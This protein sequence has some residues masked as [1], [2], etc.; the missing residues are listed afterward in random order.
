MIHTFISTETLQQP[1]EPDMVMLKVEA[2]HSSE[3]IGCIFA[4][5]AIQEVPCILWNIRVHYCIHVCP[6]HVPILS[7]TIKY[8]SKMD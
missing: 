5:S 2:I 6:P 4:A 1:S 3:T 8:A 7:K